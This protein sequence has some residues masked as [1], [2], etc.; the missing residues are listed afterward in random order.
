MIPAG[1]FRGFSTFAPRGFRYVDSASDLPAAVAG[2]ITLDP[3]VAY[4]ILGTVDLAG[5]RVAHSAGCALIGSSSEAS[6]LKSTGLTGPLITATESIPVRFLT[7]EAAHAID[8]DGT[9][10]TDPAIDWVGVNFTDCAK[11]GTIKSYDNAVFTD[12]AI[13]NS[14]EL[15]YDGSIGTVA[16]NSSIFVGTGAAKSIHI[17]KSTLTISRRWRA[18]YSAAVAFGSSTAFEVEDR[19]ATLQDED[20]VLD[21]VEFSG[22]ATYLSGIDHTNNEALIINSVGIT[23]SASVSD[24]YMV[25]NATSTPIA[26]SGTYY[27]GLGTTTSSVAEKFANTDNR[28]TYGGAVTARFSV[29]GI[30][31]VTSAN[32][33]VIGL[34]IA[35]NGTVI[36]ASTA[37]STTNA[38]SRAEGVHTQAL[39][40]LAPG[41]YVEV[42]V[43]N[44][45]GTTAVVLETLSLIVAPA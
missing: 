31:S 24:L 43:T 7:L 26:V 2:V 41:D 13:L 20:F 21:T 38:S 5:D 22:G 1:S 40:E 42:W 14:D 25:G 17:L 19:A 29:S 34:R 15:T 3:G 27:K 32:N 11:I 16:W 30:A 8:L 10:G 9:T 33:N 35:K 39:I 23:N 36:A 4:W 37:S 6:R 12:C 28:A 44:N 45:T 18:I